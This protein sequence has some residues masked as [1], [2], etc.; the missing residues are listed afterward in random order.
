MMYLVKDEYYDLKDEN[1]VLHSVYSI[2]EDDSVKLAIMHDL[3]DMMFGE[4]KNYWEKAFADGTVGCGTSEIYEFNGGH[5]VGENLID[6][7]SEENEGIKSSDLNE[8]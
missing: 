3:G 6:Y 1:R 2:I 4:P 8:N 7:V 5:T